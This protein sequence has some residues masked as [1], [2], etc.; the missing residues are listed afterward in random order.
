M[1]LL[2]LSPSSLCLL[3]C[4]LSLICVEADPR[5]ALQW[6][7][8][9]VQQN[10]NEASLPSTHVRRKLPGTGVR[11]EKKDKYDEDEDDAKSKSKKKLS[12]TKD[13]CNRDRRAVSITTTFDGSTVTEVTRDSVSGVELQFDGEYSGTWTQTTI[14]ISDNIEIGHDH[15][16]FFD[17]NGEV[18]GILT[19]QYDNTVDFAIVTAGYGEFACAQG[20]PTI[21]F[22]DDASSTMVSV[23]WDLCVCYH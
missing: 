22:P 20:A 8:L 9:Q 4:V 17:E 6:S 2:S 3:I 16:T 23:V 18:V 19:T 13:K 21:T 11:G 12:K 1:K 14:N 10:Q 5:R 7:G 15:L